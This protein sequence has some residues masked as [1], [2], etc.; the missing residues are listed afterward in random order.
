MGAVALF[1]DL[2]FMVSGDS[3]DVWARQDEFR[4]DA[5]VGVPPD[6]FSDAGQDWG[7]PAYRWDVLSERDFDWL[8]CR[9]RRNAD[10]YDGYRVDH[11][12]GFYRTYVRP[13]GGGDPQFTPA[14]QASQQAL[15][16]RVLAVFREP[17]SEIIA[18]D[19][20]T[21]PDFVRESLAQLAVPGYKV[22]RWERHWHADGQPFKDPVEY[23]AAAVATSGT[24][25]TE[26]MAVW[27]ENA[28][29]EERQAVLAIPSV[30]DRLADEDRERIGRQSGLS[31][32]LHEALL[33]SLYASGADLLILPVQD[34]F[35]WR[36]RINQP[37]T[38]GDDNWT[39]R[40]PWPCDRLGTEAAALAVGDQLREWSVRH[41][42]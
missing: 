8:R 17:G 38:T 19:L 25:D 9:A 39:W 13:H 20:G 26:P 12:V 28:P 37:A 33:E 11:L 32:A 24:H 30:R 7:L 1:G 21:V 23:P 18:E 31:H 3:A 36:D 35:G 40:L 15:G 6:A 29:P 16:E 27:W 42:R 2:P 41:G 10:L 4:L 14:D 5:S 34:V 22:F